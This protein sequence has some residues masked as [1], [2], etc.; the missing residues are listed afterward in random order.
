MPCLTTGV[1]SF[2]SRLLTAL[3]LKKLL[4]LGAVFLYW[5]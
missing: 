1:N 5:L 2:S 4:T 3:E